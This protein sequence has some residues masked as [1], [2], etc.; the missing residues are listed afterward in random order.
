[1]PV[2]GHLGAGH[3]ALGQR[4]AAHD[5]QQGVELAEVGGAYILVSSCSLSLDQEFLPELPW[6]DTLDSLPQ[7]YH[8]D[9][10]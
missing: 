7:S 9:H 3:L 1:M 4:G 5:Q 2:E 8:N 6:P 10:Q